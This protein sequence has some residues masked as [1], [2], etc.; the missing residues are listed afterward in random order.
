LVNLGRDSQMEA[1]IAN[2]MQRLQSE[3]AMPRRVPPAPAALGK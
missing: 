3:K 2:V 1:A